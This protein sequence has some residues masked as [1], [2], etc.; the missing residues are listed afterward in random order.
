MKIGNLNNKH[1]IN[2]ILDL[3]RHIQNTQPQNIRL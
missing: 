3:A 1:Y 2:K